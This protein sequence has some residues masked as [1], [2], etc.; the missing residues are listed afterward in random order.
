MTR[1]V[2][3]VIADRFHDLADTLDRNAA[4]LYGADLPEA[5]VSLRA[6]VYV[7]VAEQ[8]RLLADIETSAS[9]DNPLVVQ[10]SG[11]EVAAAVA[12]RFEALAGLLAA[13]ARLLA[14]RAVDAG[15]VR[16]AV[17]YRDIA[18]QVRIL[19]DD[20]RAIVPPRHET[21]PPL[22]NTGPVSPVA[23]DASGATFPRVRA[24]FLDP[25]VTAI[26]RR[27]RQGWSVARL[28]RWLSTT[29]R[30][31]Q[32]DEVHP[33]AQRSFVSYVARL[34]ATPRAAGLRTA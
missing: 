21:R 18:S 12:G 27:R 3:T 31:P 28:T 16:R 9:E 5:V 19:A 7:D 8:L 24:V 25:L 10:V 23:A 15:M 2:S 1:T 14:R 32:T 6:S 29:L 33:C 13:N 30:D 4:F 17:V 26:A 22:S 11:V 34:L 20:E